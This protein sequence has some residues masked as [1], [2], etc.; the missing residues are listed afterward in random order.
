[1]TTVHLCRSVTFDHESKTRNK[2]R[3]YKL[4]CYSLFA[5]YHLSSSSILS[6]VLPISIFPYFYFLQR[7]CFSSFRLV[8]IALYF[9][10]SFLPSFLSSYLPSTHPSFTLF[11][12]LSIVK[13]FFAFLS[14][15]L[16]TFLLFR[17]VRKIVKSDH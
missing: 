16:L 9:L 3:Y 14:F 13:N 10:P 8:F 7:Y 11:L 12:L 6:F 15:F 1:M 5:S 17:R 4:F 2:L